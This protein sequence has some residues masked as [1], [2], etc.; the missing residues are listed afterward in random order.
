[1]SKIKQT[2]R[3]TNLEKL[4]E[5]FQEVKTEED[6]V[7]SQCWINGRID[8]IK[9]D[10]IMKIESSKY[11]IAPG[12]CTLSLEDVDKVIEEVNRKTKEE[13]DEMFKKALESKNEDN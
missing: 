4:K 3:K 5:Y 2:P 7:R 1:M 9:R 11:P 13:I 8:A 12:K 10:R 6:L